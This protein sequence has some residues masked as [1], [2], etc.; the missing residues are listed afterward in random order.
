MKK[1]ILLL[2][3]ITLLVISGP[4]FVK[5]VK[6]GTGENISG[7]AWS[8]NIGWVSFN[9]LNCDGDGNGFSDGTPN[10]PPAGTTIANY[11]VNVDFLTG[12]FS[13]YAWS[14]NIGWITFNSSELGGCPTL[15]C[16]ARLAVDNTVSGWARA[17][18]VF[19]TGC[20]GALDPN[21]GG[22]EGWIKLRGLT[23][24]AIPTEYGVSRNTI[25]DPDEFEGWAWSDNVISW[26][27][28]N[29]LNCDPGG[30]G[31]SDGI[32]A[33]P[34]L[35]T[36][37]SDYKVFITGPV[38]QP[39]SATALPVTAGDYCSPPSPPIFLNWAYS[40]PDDVPPG[41]DPQSAYQVQ[42]DDD[43]NLDPDPLDTTP[44]RGCPNPT[45]EKVLSSSE[46]CVPIGLSFNTT[47]FW[48]VMVWDSTDTPSPFAV[49]PSFATL[50]RHPSPNFACNGQDDC[51]T[52]PISAE[53]IVTL[54]DTSTFFGGAVFSSRLWDLSLS[55]GVLEPGFTI[56]DSP[57]EVTFADGAAQP[58]TLTVTDS[59]GNSCTTT[60]TI[61]VSLPL[62][63]WREIAPTGWIEKLFAALLSLFQ[64]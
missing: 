21:R 12:A 18:A 52:V 57:I 4:L 49:G 58:V 32:G 23:T 61:N 5:E 63:E 8:E 28:F 47:Y 53:E 25:P 27:S 44:P 11:G 45:S 54:E 3:L 19:L 56:A 2:S 26:I 24:E 42:I 64:V 36:P 13:G 1:F 10:C 50:S 6:A 55:S 60:E 7:W 35:G 22:W 17:C 14:E 62:P 38:N 51:S 40:D 31:S 9:S 41:T 37:I 20:S 39:P 30:D 16:E 15:P 59:N 46:T 33:C 43:S 34:P 29:R 48:R